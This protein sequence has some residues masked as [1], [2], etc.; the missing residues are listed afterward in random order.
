MRQALS[1]FQL[2]GLDPALKVDMGMLLFIL[3]DL[4]TPGKTSKTSNS[5]THW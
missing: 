3:L 2:P 5:T 1:Q 4:A